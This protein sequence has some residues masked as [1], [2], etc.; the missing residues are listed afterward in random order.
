MNVSFLFWF[1]LCLLKKYKNSVCFSLITLSFEICNLSMSPLKKSIKLNSESRRPR[2]E[3]KLVV[4][5]K[6]ADQQYSK[7]K[8]Y[9][10]NIHILFICNI[11]ILGLFLWKAPFQ[12]THKF[13]LDC[14]IDV[15]SMYQTFR[16]KYTVTSLSHLSDYS[17][18]FGFETNFS[19]S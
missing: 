11:S 6:V 18:F 10:D 19:Q 7:H 17:L 1:F 2:N 8:C 13:E 15:L 16:I 4:C 14:F 3:W 12:I 5:P 9:H